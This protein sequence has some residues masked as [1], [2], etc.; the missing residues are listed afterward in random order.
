VGPAALGGPYA[1]RNRADEEHD[2]D[3]LETRR[4]IRLPEHYSGDAEHAGQKGKQ[5]HHGISNERAN[6]SPML[7]L[8]G[9]DILD[10]VSNVGPV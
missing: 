3:E 6:L 1:Q 5:V 8:R 2:P 4:V 9:V 7:P 10:P